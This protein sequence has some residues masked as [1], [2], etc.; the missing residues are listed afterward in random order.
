MK[1]SREVK[2]HKPKTLY[3]ST[4]QIKGH[5]EEAVEKLGSG[6]GGLI[7][8]ADIYPDTPLENIEALCQAFEEQGHYVED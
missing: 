5:V 7:L 8:S 6:E 2:A 3:Q 4:K 1:L